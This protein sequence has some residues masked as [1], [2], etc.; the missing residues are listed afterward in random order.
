VVTVLRELPHFVYNWKSLE[1]AKE[2]YDFSKIEADLK[3]LDGM[4][5]KMFIQVQD[6]FFSVG[7][8]NVPAYLMQDAV[9]GGGVA[10]QSDN[11]GE[12]QP[13]GSGWVA[14]QWNPNLRKQF[15]KLL[16]ALALQFD[17]RVYG[18]NLPETS[19][20]LDIKHDHTGFGCDKYFN[21]ELE[22]MKFARSVFRKSYVV[23]YVN[24]WPCE[25]DNDH[26]Y[27][28]RIFEYAAQNNIGLG[29]PDIVPGNKAQMRNSYPFF[30]QYKD[31]LVLVAMAVQE[32]T[33]TYT[34]PETGKP[35]T[36]EEFQRFGR[37]Y[38]GAKIIFWSA[39]A[40]WLRTK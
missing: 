14:E 34:N 8:K 4:H 29:G 16:R 28:S 24:F 1:A 37:D 18:V 11:A 9:Y 19:A 13:V 32:P 20:E 36:K 31:R 40:P 12:N 21:A 35:F 6:R 25:W 23:Q 27:M 7:D 30:H 17:G 39:S 15:Q 38:L 5:K 33:L 22:N 2:Q 26:H 10:P 3:I